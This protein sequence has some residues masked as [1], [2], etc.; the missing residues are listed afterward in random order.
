M[1]WRELERGWDAGWKNTLS[2]IGGY[3]YM[4][5]G[6]DRSDDYLLGYAVGRDCAL[7]WNRG[8]QDGQAW[9]RVGRPE[10]AVLPEY[11]TGYRQGWADR[12]RLEELCHAA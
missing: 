1:N 2:Q 11:L 10:E 4:T 5:P 12:R 6:M 8:Y 9:R 3:S 7:A